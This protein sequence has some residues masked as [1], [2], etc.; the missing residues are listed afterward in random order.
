[1]TNKYLKFHINHIRNVI[2]ENEKQKGPK[3]DPWGTPEYA[4]YD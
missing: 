2:E 1:M 4:S 3:L